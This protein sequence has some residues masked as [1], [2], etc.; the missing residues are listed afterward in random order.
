VPPLADK[1]AETDPPI[2]VEIEFGEG[3]IDKVG[4]AT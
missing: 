1:M 3:V 4:Y 2:V